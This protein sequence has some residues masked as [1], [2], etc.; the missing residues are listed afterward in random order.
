ML[1]SASYMT[2]LYLFWSFVVFDKQMC[3]YIY[4]VLRF[5]FEFT[6]TVDVNTI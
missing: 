2:S 4:T 3:C 5:T 1:S 6:I